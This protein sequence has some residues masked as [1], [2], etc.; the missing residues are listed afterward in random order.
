M[1]AYSYGTMVNSCGPADQPVQILVLTS[2]PLTCNQ[3][4]TE[5]YISLMMGRVFAYPKTVTFPTENPNGDARRCAGSCEPVVSG[6]I[7]LDRTAKKG[8][9]GHYEL[10]F[11]EG[12]RATGTFQVRQCMQR[13][14]CW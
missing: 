5:P 1:V 8:I 7:V 2:R 6:T 14:V 10:K 13:I 11:K 4:P 12:D 9:A 3:K